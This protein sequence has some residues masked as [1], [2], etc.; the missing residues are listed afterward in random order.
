MSMPFDLTLK[1]CAY[2]LRKFE[3]F[4]VFVNWLLS[5]FAW[6]GTLANYRRGGG[7][8]GWTSPYP[9]LGQRSLWGQTQVW[10]SWY[11]RSS[12]P[13][14][15]LHITLDMILSYLKSL[16]CRVHSPVDW[17]IPTSILYPPCFDKVCVWRY[18]FPFTD[19]NVLN[20]CHR[21][22]FTVLYW[23]FYVIIWA[24]CSL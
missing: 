7:L 15:K 11:G 8:E 12:N 6:N 23:C 19:G 9:F 10:L 20:K 5:S 14:I 21:W 13:H 18:W 1:S 3:F 24:Y 4:D 2:T 22:R 16:S 17:W